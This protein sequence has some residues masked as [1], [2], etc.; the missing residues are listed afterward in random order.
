ML[1][2]RERSSTDN[3]QPSSER[4]A[5]V[6]LAIAIGGQCCDTT[7][8]SLRHAHKRFERAQKVAFDGMLL[9]PSL[10]MICIFLLMSIYMLGACRRNGA[11]M[12]LGVAARSAH[13][14]GLHVPESYLHLEPGEHSLR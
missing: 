4:G 10:D 11:F 5:I 6:D 13:A 14:L 9:D 1:E 3:P 7:P 8:E 12:Y 2:E